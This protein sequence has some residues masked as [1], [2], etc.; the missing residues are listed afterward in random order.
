MGGTRDRDMIKSVMADL[1]K[2]AGKI[3][4]TS[5]HRQV[6]YGQVRPDRSDHGDSGPVLA[7][8]GGLHSG[9][10]H[11]HVQIEIINSTIQN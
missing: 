6:V 1:V 9:L 11:H 8:E 5:S 4:P 3:V 7:G 10:Q 2:L